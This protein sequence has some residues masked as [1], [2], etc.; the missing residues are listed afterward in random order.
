MEVGMGAIGYSSD[1]FWRMTRRELMVAW[2]GKHPEIKQ[3]A[4]EM[5]ELMEFMDE[6]KR[7]ERNGK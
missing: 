1:Q 7:K 3:R 6:M 2:H 4:R 5:D